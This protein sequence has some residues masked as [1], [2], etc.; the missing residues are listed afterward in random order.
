MPPHSLIRWDA[1]AI[2]GW[3]REAPA[4][5]D[6]PLARIALIGPVAPATAAAEAI[7]TWGADTPQGS[8]V[9]VQLRAQVG[10][11]WSKY[12]RVAS[13]DSAPAES[14]RTS[15]E[16]QRDDDGQLAT[17]TLLLTAP[18]SALQARVLLCAAPGAD[19]PELESLAL[20][21][22]KDEGRTSN[23][24]GRMTDGGR[25]TGQEHEGAEPSPFVLRRSPIA[26]PLLLSQYSYPDGGENWCSPTSLT[27]VLAAWH[28]LTGEARLEPFSVPMCVPAL[29]VPL[30]FDPGWEGTGNWAFNTALAASLGLTAYVTRLHSL[31]QLARWTAAGVPVPISIRWEPGELDGA[32][33]RSSGHITVVTGVEGDRVHM[34]EP[35]AREATT[36]VRSYRA[37]QLYACWQ[38]ASRGAAYIIHP[39]G[40]QRP[41]PGP[42]DAWV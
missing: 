12:Y 16:P 13:W 31:E 26:M 23:D 9:E 19:M 1:D 18:A 37:D 14:R 10:E 22:T 7:P 27:M 30:V 29:S 4:P 41:E 34:A 6:D 42:G 15:F 17:D 38:R 5:E 28:G 35:A 20:C 25:A 36:I 32:S 39:R 2:A 24:E 40:W 33:G 3:E 21:A 11:R 8:W